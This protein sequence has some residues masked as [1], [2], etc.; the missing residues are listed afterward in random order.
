MDPCE[1]LNNGSI[2]I[3]A[4]SNSG[5]S[6]SVFVRIFGPPDLFPGDSLRLGETLS[7]NDQALPAGPYFIQVFDP[8]GSSFTT[9]PPIELVD[10]TTPL[11]VSLVNSMN[12][13]DIGCFNPNGF[14]NV[15]VA[16]GTGSYSFQWTSTSTVPFNDTNQ[17]ISDLAGGVY[18]LRVFD[19][20]TNC[21]V[22]LSPSITL[23][24]PTPST[25]NI[26]NPS[27]ETICALDDLTILLDGSDPLPTPPD[28]PVP[29]VYTIFINSGSGPVD[30]GITAQ[31][32]GSAP[33][34]ILIGSGI[35]SD[36]DI[37]TVRATQGNCATVDMVGSVTVD[38]LIVPVFTGNLDA[39]VCSGDATGVILPSVDD[40]GDGIT[41]YDV[42]AVVGAGLTGTASTATGT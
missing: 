39:T 31:G 15:S 34:A 36:D 6:D 42:S 29:V 37:I 16:G 11:T 13:T 12:N 14:I 7:F 32:D 19:N 24:D 9:I 18:D 22:D 28:P 33:F 41:S 30:S 27:N 35:L 1:G 21:F 2:F 40:D 25:F 10:I 20:N 17:N 23:T 3:R 4:I 38:V 5:Q 8:N 26:L